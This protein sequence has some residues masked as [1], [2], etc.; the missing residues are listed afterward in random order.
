[1]VTTDTTRAPSALAIP[2]AEYSFMSIIKVDNKKK[3]C[4]SDYRNYET[5]APEGAPY[6]LL[7][8]A[9][10]DNIDLVATV[11]MRAGLS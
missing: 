4:L 6:E 3:V 10:P 5:E 11:E 7:S 1:M 2:D 8:P 9:A